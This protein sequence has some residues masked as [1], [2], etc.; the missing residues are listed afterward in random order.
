MNLTKLKVKT[1]TSR[2]AKS[3]KASKKYQQGY[4][5]GPNHNREDDLNVTGNGG[6]LI[7]ALNTYYV[8]IPQI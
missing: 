5:A 8:R 1:A 4:F 2:I 7:R 3:L 6:C